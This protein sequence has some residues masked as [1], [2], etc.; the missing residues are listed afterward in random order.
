MKNNIESDVNPVVPISDF[1]L[2]RVEQPIRKLLAAA[3][4]EALTDETSDLYSDVWANVIA[5]LPE[6]LKQR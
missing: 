2:T 5:C 1:V 4:D 6:A 3:I